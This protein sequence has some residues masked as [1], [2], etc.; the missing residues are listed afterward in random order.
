[1]HNHP[2]RSTEMYVLKRMFSKYFKVLL[3][4]GSGKLSLGRDKKKKFCRQLVQS[5]F[6]LFLQS[7]EDFTI[8]QLTTVLR[9]YT[10]EWFMSS[11]Y[12]NCSF[13]H[14]AIFGS[15]E[16]KVESKGKPCQIA[17]HFLRIYF[18]IIEV[19][20]VHIIGALMR[21]I[22]IDKKHSPKFNVRLAGCVNY[23]SVKLKV[24]FREHERACILGIHELT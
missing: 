17:F 4:Y 2:I 9:I 11:N 16:L 6:F 10:K 15:G 24:A 12:E 22:V 19:G 14:Y 5:G 18:L 23:L 8:C 3:T 20:K 21:K 13:V 7:S 1:M